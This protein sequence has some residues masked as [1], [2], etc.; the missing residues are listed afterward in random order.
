MSQAAHG[1][2][3][4]GFGALPFSQL[5]VDGHVLALEILAAT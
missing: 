3:A 2:V 5:H 4:Y 1:P